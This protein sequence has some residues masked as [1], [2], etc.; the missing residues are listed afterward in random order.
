MH[1][2]RKILIA[3]DLFSGDDTLVL[4]RAKEIV[5]SDSEIS[6]VHV[7]EPFYNF[8]S[9]YVVE[10]ISEWQEH[11]VC[12]AEKKLSQLGERFSI[13][14]HRLLVR[15]GRVQDE[16]FA[17]AQSLHADLVLLGSHGRYGADLLNQ[18]SASH[19][20]IACDILTIY[21]PCKKNSVFSSQK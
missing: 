6:L 3:V 11:T 14:S 4:K 5:A 7:V 1:F 17:A 21:I 8:I 19:T 10:S 2:Y 18:L 20:E 15:L 12:L 9:P 13:P 16:I